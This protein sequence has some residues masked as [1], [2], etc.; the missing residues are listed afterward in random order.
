M[1]KSSNPCFL[2][3]VIQTYPRSNITKA[4]ESLDQSTVRESQIM[5]ELTSQNRG[6]NPDDDQGF[7][8]CVSHT[9][10]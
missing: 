1:N 6:Q 9:L 8:L 2:L 4:F 10:D 7:A 3:R 5:Q